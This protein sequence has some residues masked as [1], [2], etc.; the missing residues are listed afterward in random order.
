MRRIDAVLEIAGLIAAGWFTH[1][2][3]RERSVVPILQERAA[4]R[5]RLDVVADQL[6]CIAELK[7]ST[8]RLEARFQEKAD[9]AR[10]IDARF[11]KDETDRLWV[12]ELQE[13]IWK[14]FR[15]LQVTSEQGSIAQPFELAVPGTLESALSSL[16]RRLSGLLG[17]DV[18]DASRERLRVRG[19]RL[20]AKF[21]VTGSY[22]DLLALLDHLRAERFH[23]EL[24][25]LDVRYERPDA[26]RGDRV[27]AGVSVAAFAF[28]DTGRE[29]PR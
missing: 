11:L 24:T 23:V 19:F 7:E 16:T 2:L 28:R 12:V 27:G 6:S 4:L 13:R 20:E 9:L 18:P 15:Q 26:V 17:K 5:A 21:R 25:R 8:P 10:R 1:G 22:T 3:I 14:R 29:R